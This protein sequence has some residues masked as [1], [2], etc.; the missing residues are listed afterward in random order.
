MNHK[1]NNL[2]EYPF[3]F[4]NQLLKDEKTISNKIIDLSIGEPKNSPPPEVFKILKDKEVTLS[5]YPTMKGID[6]LRN[7]FC[8]YLQNR[9]QLKDN[10]SPEKNVLPL[11][12]TREGLF[13]FIQYAVNTNQEDPTVV[14]PNPVYKIYEGATI[15]A[16]A[17]PYFLDCKKEDNFRPDLEAVPKNIWESCQLL[18]LCSPSNPTGYCMSLEEYSYA[19]SLAEKYDF[20]ICSDECYIDLYSSKRSAPNSL[21]EL[22]EFSNKNFSRIATFHSLSKRSNL[23][24]LRSGFITSDAKTISKFH[25]YRTYHGVAMP[26]PS[27]YASAWAWTDENHVMINRESY[28][29]KYDSFIGALDLKNSI[30]RPPGAFYIWLETP[31]CDELFTKNLYKKHG[32]KVLPGSYLGIEEFSINPGK[33]FIRLA[34]VHDNKTVEIAAQAINEVLNS[35]K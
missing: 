13:S 24:G 18:I 31:Y 22:A 30:K 23:A 3:F 2:S 14:M 6:S 8:T 34:I 20:I 32:V 10:P 5:Q 25:L 26:L 21:I 19:L 15:L 17:K 16:G 33:N 4:L 1:I 27:Q 29:Q 12:G 35:A 11:S 28:D 9:F 7:S